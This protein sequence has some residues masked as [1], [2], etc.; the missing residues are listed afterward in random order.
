MNPA[1][2]LTITWSP[3]YQPAWDANP[4]EYRAADLVGWGR[5]RRLARATDPTRA[6]KAYLGVHHSAWQDEDITR[7]FLSLFI[8]GRTISLRTFATLPEA[9]EE[10]HAFYAR[11]R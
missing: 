10:L 9:L 8:A 5:S 11:L 4:E 7:F 6:F 3:I 2:G 1:S